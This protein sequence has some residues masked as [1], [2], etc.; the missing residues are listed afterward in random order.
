MSR[1][2]IDPL[3]LGTFMGMR[4]VEAP[5]HP[6][7]TLPDDVPPPPGMTRA[8]FAAW[9]REVCGVT[10]VVPRGQAYIVNGVALVRPEDA[11]RLSALA[12]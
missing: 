5:T 11:V 2:L 8:E 12:I 7:Y 3:G 6:R 4:I 1:S 9:S 10:S